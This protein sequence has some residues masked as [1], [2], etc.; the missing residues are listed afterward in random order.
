LYQLWSVE[1]FFKTFERNKRGEITTK[2]V[3]LK[4]NLPKLITLVYK[5]SSFLISLELFCNRPCAL[6]N[7][8]E[9]LFE[10][11]YGLQRSDWHLLIE[12]SRIIK[13]LMYFSWFFNS[14]NFYKSAILAYI[15]YICPLFSTS[16]NVRSW[17]FLCSK[18]TISI[19]SKRQESQDLAIPTKIWTN[20]FFIPKIKTLRRSS[21]WKFKNNFFALH[22]SVLKSY[23]S[24]RHLLFPV[25]EKNWIVF[26]L[27]LYAKKNPNKVLFYFIFLKCNLC[28]AHFFLDNFFTP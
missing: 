2:T 18:K 12:D 14:K 4:Q 6:K 24:F 8:C 10:I 21:F 25:C 28:N 3:N 22:R 19:H 20:L 23:P 16:L 1:F 27:Y 5:D 9:P 17:I 15:A 26:K 7:Y 13:L 11:H